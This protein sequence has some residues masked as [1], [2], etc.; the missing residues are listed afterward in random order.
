[1]NKNL[2]NTR[3]V[4]RPFRKLA[5]EWSKQAK[6]N[7]KTAMELRR[8]QTQGSIVEACQLESDAALLLDKAKELKKLATDVLNDRISVL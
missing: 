3:A 2:I 5:Q 1:M 6:I 8:N 7:M 4:V